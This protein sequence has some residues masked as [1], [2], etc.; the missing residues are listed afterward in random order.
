[1]DVFAIVDHFNALK[2]PVQPPDV[3]HGT[4]GT[5]VV[6]FVELSICRP[7]DPLPMLF[8]DAPSSEQSLV[9]IRFAAIAPVV[10]PGPPSMTE[11][12][13]NRTP[14]TFGAAAT[15]ASSTKNRE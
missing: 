1:M 12:P 8:S 15:A 4:V 13:E 6:L 7:A 9:L 11:C 2:I 10:S 5:P 3:L 14:A